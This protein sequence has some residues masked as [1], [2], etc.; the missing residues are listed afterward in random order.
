MPLFAQDREAFTKQIA[1]EF[2]DELS[3]VD[4]SNKSAQ[5]MKMTL[6][7]GLL[8]AA[9]KHQTELKR[10]GIDIGDPLSFGK[11]GEEVGARLALECPGFL[12]AM[13]GTPGRLQE[14][15]SGNDATGSI[16]GKLL[17]IVSGDFTYL[18]I[19]DSKGKIEK[20]W[21]MEYFDGSTKLLTDPQNRLNKAIT[22]TYVEKEMFNSTLNDYVKMKVIRK[23]E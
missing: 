21:W 11:F 12:S 9:G 2:C 22:V 7:V 5:D 3:K 18:Q 17:K 20:L 19:E 15:I 16:S 6:G 23:I 10:F 14:L 13:T 1:K 8:N 4:F